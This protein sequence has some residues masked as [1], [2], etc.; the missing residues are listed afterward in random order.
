MWLRISNLIEAE[1]GS[2]ARSQTPPSNGLVVSFDESKLAAFF[3]PAFR[4]SR[5]DRFGGFGSDCV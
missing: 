4:T 1:K 3:S 2:P 5:S